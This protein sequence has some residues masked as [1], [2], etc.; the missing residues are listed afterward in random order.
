[1]NRLA[2]QAARAAG[3]AGVAKAALAAGAAQAA[4]AARAAL[5]ALAA[6]P[7]SWTILESIP[8]AKDWDMTTA[9][10]HINYSQGA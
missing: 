5:A 2:G 4:Q 6:F 8:T 7:G 10:L 3:A 1:M 9:N